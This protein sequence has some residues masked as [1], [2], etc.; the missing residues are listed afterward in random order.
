MGRGRARK[1]IAAVSRPRAAATNAVAA[2]A[3]VPRRRETWVKEVQRYQR[4]ASLLIPKLPF[5]RLVKETM[6]RVTGGAGLRI[7]SQAMGCLQVREE[8]S[9]SE[10]EEWEGKSM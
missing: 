7:Q 4:D 6:E 2:A 9:G 8:Q 10:G 3:A 1:S 5:M